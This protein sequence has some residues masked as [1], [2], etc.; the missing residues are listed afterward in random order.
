MVER[1]QDIHILH[2]DIETE[3]VC[4]GSDT[5]WVIGLGQRYPALLQ[6]VADQDLLRGPVVLLRN[7]DKGGVI[8]FVVANDG[9]VGFDDDA[10][11][12]AVCVDGALLTPW[13]ELYRKADEHKIIPIAT[14][15]TS[16]A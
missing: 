1:V 14:N 13:V 12:L 16:I 9:R 11:L 2:A 7:L 15:P 4:I 5:F 8:G 3:H 10:V 6:R